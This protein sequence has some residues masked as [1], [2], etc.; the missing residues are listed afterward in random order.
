MKP[1]TPPYPKF[2]SRFVHKCLVVFYRALVATIQHEAVKDVA[3]AFAEA[4]KEEQPMLKE[5][6]K[7]EGLHKSVVKERLT[8]L[9]APV[10]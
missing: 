10:R 9:E 3:D 6:E 2:V 5:E 7:T 8:P 1:Q 4:L